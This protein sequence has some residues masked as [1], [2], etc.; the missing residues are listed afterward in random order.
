MDKTLRKKYEL[1]P[2]QLKYECDSKEFELTDKIDPGLEAIIIGQEKAV[3]AIQK[4]LKLD[5]KHSNIFVTGQQGLGKDEIIETVLKQYI[6]KLS[7]EEYK[8]KLRQ[9]KD[10]L[11]TCN[12]GNPENP[13]ILELPQGFGKQ[14]EKDLDAAVNYILKDGIEVY[15]KQFEMESM[16]GNTQL[17]NLSKKLGNQQAKF[18]KEGQKIQAE[19]IKLEKLLQEAQ[20]GSKEAE[21][22]EKKIEKL[23]QK[24]SEIDRDSLEKE[25]KIQAEMA[26]I[27]SRIMSDQKN[28]S[29][30]YK[31]RV[32]KPI[33]DRLK[34]NYPTNK[35]KNYLGQLEKAIM[36]DVEKEIKALH[37]SI[38]ANQ[39]L[40]TNMMLQ[41]PLP[42][43]T[44]PYEVKI[45]NEL[46]LEEQ[47]KGIPVIYEKKPT[48]E[49]LFGT[50]KLPQYVINPN[51]LEKIKKDNHIRLRAGSFIKAKGGYLI[52]NTPKIV[53]KDLLALERLL[54][55]LD[56]KT[57]I[58]N[59]RLQYYDSTASED[60]DSNVK[61]I[62]TGNNGLYQQLKRISSAGFFEEFNKVFDIKAELDSVTDNTPKA[63]KL[64]SEYV[65]RFCNKKG[66]KPVTPKGI[67]EIINYSTRVTNNQNELTLNLTKIARVIREANMKAENNKE[68][69]EEHIIKAVEAIR[70]RH[71][72]IE[73]KV[74]DF[75][76]KGKVLLDINNWQNEKINGVAV[77]TLEDITFGAPIRIT[78]VS[79]LGKGEMINIDRDA[80]LAEEI[81][82]KATRIMKGNFKD[83]FAKDKFVPVDTSTCFEQNYGKIDGDSATLAEFLVVL[84]SL[85]GCPIDQGIAVTG[86]LNQL[87]EVQ[88]IGGVNEKIEGVYDICKAKG[89]TGT[90]GVMIPKTNADELK[91]KNETIKDVKEGKFHIYAVG[92]REE[93]IE[94]MFGMK[95]G[96][97]K[98]RNFEENS[99]YYKVN[100]QIK[101]YNKIAKELKKLQ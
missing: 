46:K 14:F 50:V 44:S 57:N 7:P 62:I 98:D 41:M 15:E 9:R 5:D 37:M 32:V 81:M 63:R 64:Y 89:L 99:L 38:E 49:R 78:A 96:Y 74:H 16:L 25:I 2:E 75:I 11:A 8:Q 27:Q 61:V 42:P 18:Q 17:G 85:S 71:N 26:D 39:G 90:Q 47:I 31:E 69:T 45:I 91:L 73:K 22:Y 70:S 87:G 4:G 53:Q 82:A 34:Q 10:L 84:S 1:K 60:T 51:G 20:S 58:E 83:L 93:A 72:L 67:A 54:E 24:Y 59:I 88:P 28:A 65:A 94:V 66:Y 86:S 100:K 33:L 35:I 79:C 29:T 21:E 92:T 55:E 76:K 12:F 23:S 77:Y 52:L 6:E 80:Q 3:E 30:N 97:K 48:L 101:Q 68:I 36:H 19:I 95:S 40:T 43:D 13:L 56:G